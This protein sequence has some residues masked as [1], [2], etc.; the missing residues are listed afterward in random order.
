MAS[1]VQR[2]TGNQHTLVSTC[3][4]AQSNLLY[5]NAQY[6]TRCYIDPTNSVAKKVN[7]RKRST[8]SDQ[9]LNKTVTQ[10]DYSIE[11]NLQT[12]QR[13][14][15]MK[16][17]GWPFYLIS[18]DLPTKSNDACNPQNTSHIKTGE[19]A[20]Q[21]SNFHQRPSWHKVSTRRCLFHSM[22]WLQ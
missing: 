7:E 20:G 19:K 15:N 6:W 5:I 21:P 13:A 4:F 17:E 10:T 9:L 8:S 12:Q 1:L 11:R 2:Y 16:Q 22:P 14:K 3:I 18:R